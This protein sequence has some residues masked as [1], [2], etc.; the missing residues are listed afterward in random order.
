MIDETYAALQYAGPASWHHLIAPTKTFTLTEATMHSAA[1]SMD[2]VV[3]NAGSIALI[4]ALTDLCAT[5]AILSNA[6]ANT[7]FTRNARDVFEEARLAA[8]LLDVINK[9]SP[10][11]NPSFRTYRYFKQAMG[12]RDRQV[13][14]FLLVDTIRV[15]NH[16]IKK[17]SNSE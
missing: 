2:A 16:I 10:A 5:S 7:T 4:Y 14:H 13:L 1:L 17:A 8:N 12:T 6:I 15:G 9:N 11:F 3:S